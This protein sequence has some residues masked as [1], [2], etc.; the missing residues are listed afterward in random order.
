[1]FLCGIALRIPFHGV[2]ARFHVGKDGGVH[3]LFHFVG[4]NQFAGTFLFHRVGDE[5]HDGSLRVEHAEV[6]IRASAAASTVGEGR[7]EQIGFHHAG[8]AAQILGERRVAAGSLH[9]DVSALWNVGCFESRLGIA[10]ELGHHARVEELSFAGVDLKRGSV[11]ESLHLRCVFDA[12]VA[13][14]VHGKLGHRLVTAEFAP[15]V[16][17]EVQVAFAVGFGIDG[18]IG[19]RFEIRLV[20]SHRERVVSGHQVLRFENGLSGRERKTAHEVAR[21]AV[22]DLYVQRSIV[23]IR[24]TG[25]FPFHTAR[26]ITGGLC[27]RN[28]A[29]GEADPR[30]RNDKGGDKIQS[31]VFCSH[32]VVAGRQIVDEHIFFREVVFHDRGEG[33]PRGRTCALHSEFNRAGFGGVGHAH[34]DLTLGHA[35]HRVVDQ[36][37]SRCIVLAFHLEVR[38]HLAVAG[39]FSS[40]YHISSGSQSRKGMSKVGVVGRV[41]LH[42]RAGIVRCGQVVDDLLH[43]RHLRSLHFH[44]TRAGTARGNC[45]G[46]QV[47][48]AH[49]HVA[50]QFE[51]AVVPVRCRG[52]RRAARFGSGNHRVIAFRQ[53]EECDAFVGA[54]RALRGNHRVG[55]VALVEVEGRFREIGGSVDPGLHAAARTHARTGGRAA[56]SERDGLRFAQVDSAHAPIVGP[57]RGAALGGDAY[58]ERL[59]V[60]RGGHIYFDS[61]PR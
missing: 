53:V 30:F 26:R 48:S 57:V 8:H 1:M 29:V 36:R 33:Q 20:I 61:R 9:R 22:G 24:A 11:H 54:R 35:R 46:N 23:E 12:A 14:I 58:E 6:N 27:T 13:R 39:L 55:V 2:I 4:A 37:H 7:T 44:P 56:R 10:G 51:G 34:V 18:E 41:G 43:A 32:Q 47:E 21:V 49:T 15:L 16:D 50:G 59:P 17:G 40:R 5:R 45:R 28:S 25:Q 60:H 19:V 3:A 38:L 42:H 31:T 52:G